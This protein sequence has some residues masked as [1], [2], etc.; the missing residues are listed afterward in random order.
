MNNRKVKYRYHIK[1]LYLE[2]IRNVLIRKFLFNIL[3]M[4]AEERMYDKIKELSDLTQ[5]NIGMSEEFFLNDRNQ[6]I[7]I[8]SQWPNSK[9]RAIVI[10]L[11]G[12][13]SHVNRPVHDHISKEFLSKDIAYLSMDFHGHGYSDGLKAY[14]RSCDHLISEVLDFVKYLF[15]NQVM[16]DRHKFSQNAKKDTPF[17][18]MGHSMGGACAIAAAHYLN[19]SIESS[20][21][22]LVLLCP[23]ID[24]ARPS[25]PVL[26]LITYVIVPLFPKATIPAY[27][28]TVSN[29]GNIWHNKHYRDYVKSD[30]YPNNP[31]G[32]SWGMPI[33]YQTG[34]SVLAIAARARAAVSSIT[35][36]FLVFHD[37]EDKVISI[38]GTKYLLGSSATDVNEKMYIE[39]PQGLHDLLANRLDLITRKS[40]EWILNDLN[41]W[42]ER[43]QQVGMLPIPMHYNKLCD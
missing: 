30:Q 27:S 8:R 42:M 17:Y 3:E 43:Q 2:I 41:I 15:S 1:C 22:G 28:T 9:P 40:V 20:F 16:S 26:A 23:A 13:A 19:S 29:D 36:P 35:Y 12:Y 33:R 21:R 32:L 34:S 25:A 18:L 6:K 39:V 5:I 24:C 4:L 7:H 14:V 37:P 38:Q 10:F 11:H 31:N